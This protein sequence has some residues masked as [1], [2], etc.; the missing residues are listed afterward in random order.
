MGVTPGITV[1]P[2]E[3][4]H[5]PALAEIERLC[6]STPWQAWMLEEEL[7]NP[8]ALFAVAVRESVPVGYA[9]MTH[10]CGEGYI[11]NVAVHPAC[12]RQGTATALLRYLDRQAR[13]RGFSLLTLEARVSNAGAIRLYEREGFVRQGVRPGFYERPREDAL[14]M[15]KF[16]G[17][18]CGNPGRG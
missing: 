18:A 4:A 3:E 1:V 6:F 11:D 17:P 5:I 2:M 12:R 9:G 13:T 14:I 16:Y 15:T 7:E 10:V 8:A